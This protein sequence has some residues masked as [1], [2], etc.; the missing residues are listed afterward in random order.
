[1]Q[2]TEQQATVI[3]L[4][5]QRRTRQEITD[6]LGF[7][8]A[9]YYQLLDKFSGYGLLRAEGELPVGAESA[10]WPSG[11]WVSICQRASSLL[12]DW[13]PALIHRE[14]RHQA[15]AGLMPAKTDPAQWR[16]HTTRRVDWLFDGHRWVVQ[17]LLVPHVDPQAVAADRTVVVTEASDPINGVDDDWRTTRGGIVPMGMLDRPQ[18]GDLSLDERTGLTLAVAWVL[19]ARALLTPE[20]VIKATVL[21]ARDE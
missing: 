5:E 8:R 21:A 2:L 14:N 7:S 10:T 17:G 18:M 16:G 9:Y 19:E 20:A 3:S 13:D 1:M 12:E 15:R 11:P 4:L 6:A